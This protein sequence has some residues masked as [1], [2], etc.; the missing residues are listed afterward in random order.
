MAFTGLIE[1]RILIRELLEAYADASTRLDGEKWAACWVEDSLWSLPEY[2]EIGEM[3]GKSAIVAGWKAA[4]LDHPNFV[5]INSP[6][7]I[8]ISGNEAHV[9]TYSSEVFDGKDG[10]IKRTRGRYDDVV[11]KV[12]G[13]WLFQS[14]IY[15]NLRLD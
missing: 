3:R 11:V 5:M 8:E 12:N 15:K 7:A 13:Q 6:G 10:A 1:D 14:R 2:P 4:M 9:R